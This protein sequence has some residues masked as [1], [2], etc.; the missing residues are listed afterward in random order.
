[1]LALWQCLRGMQQRRSFL[2]PFLA[3]I[4]ESTLT[5]WICPYLFDS[6]PGSTVVLVRFVV[7]HPISPAINWNSSPILA[8][9]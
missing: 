9:A 8:A 4:R 3:G 7:W 1:M 2:Q 5:K 6:L